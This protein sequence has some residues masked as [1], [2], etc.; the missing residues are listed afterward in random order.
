MPRYRADGNAQPARGRLRGGARAIATMCALMV[1]GRWRKLAA[2]DESKHLPVEIAAP[3]E[4]HPAEIAKRQWWRMPIGV[5]LAAGFALLTVLAGLA[6]FLTLAA[7]AQTSRNLVRDRNETILT[8]I[9]ARMRDHLDAV[10]KQAEHVAVL[11]AGRRFDPNDSATLFAYLLGSM[12][13]N[14][15]TLSIS[16]TIDNFDTWRALRMADGVIAVEKTNLAD[17]PAIS[18]RFGALRAAKL[19]YWGDLLWNPQ[20]GEALINLRVP[21]RRDEQFVGGVLATVSTA[22]L[23]RYVLDDNLSDDRA[24]FVLFD[25]QFVLAHARFLGEKMPDLPSNQLL[26]KVDQIG[27]PILAAIWSAE[28]TRPAWLPP[29]SGHIAEANGK[30]YVYLLKDVRGYGDKP[31]LVGRYFPLSDIDEDFRQLRLAAIAAG[32]LLVV[33]FLITF[34][35]GRW[36]G[37]PVRRLAIAAGHLRNFEFEGEPLRRSGLRELD[38]AALAFNASRSAL[39]WFGTYVPRQL[40]TRLM[41]EG[42]GALSFKRRDVSVMFTDIVGFTPQAEHLGERQ[43][44]EFLNHHFALLA[45]CI[46]AEGGAIDKFIGDSVMATWGAIK[47][48]HDHAD[49]ALRSALAIVAALRADNA[50]RRAAGEAPVRLRIGLHCGPVV[51][52]NIGAPG[53]INYTVVGD[54]VNTAQRLEQLGKEY[55]NEAEEAVLLVSAD[56]VAALHDPAQFA[57]LL[58]PPQRHE[59]RGRSEGLALHKVRI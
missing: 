29:G 13:A 52:G 33:A 53:R 16:F 50:R 7:G 26:F 32:V 39:R 47:R 12:G 56:L 6:V 42:E 8:L 54:T 51:I 20:Q 40:V 27:D 21:A 45:H 14:P 30:S 31:W 34:A 22:G 15:Q 59:V 19:P 38:D 18:E 4:P 17:Y 57:D 2:M 35:M 25:R 44:A 55:M 36:I 58:E 49:A 41:A 1:P 11:I 5:A 9:E 10:A 3:T 23:S 28:R 37:R 46:D 48:S 24:S 43:I